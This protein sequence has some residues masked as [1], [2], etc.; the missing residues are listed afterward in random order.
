MMKF[1]VTLRSMMNCIKKVKP[2]DY[3]SEKELS[4]LL[5]ENP[6]KDLKLEL[7]CQDGKHYYVNLQID[8]NLGTVKIQFPYWSMPRTERNIAFLY[9]LFLAPR[10]K[11]STVDGIT[12][13]NNYRTERS[14]TKTKKKEIFDNENENNKTN[15]RK[16]RLEYQVY[17]E[18]DISKPYLKRRKKTTNLFSA[19]EYNPE[20]AISINEKNNDKSFD[21]NEDDSS[22]DTLNDMN[23]DFYQNSLLI[24]GESKKNKK[25]KNESSKAT[26]NNQK[27]FE[28]GKNYENI[29]STKEIHTNG[30]NHLITE[31]N[32]SIGSS[33]NG[34][35]NNYPQDSH[36]KDVK[37]P[38]ETAQDGLIS[39]A[40]EI[41]AAS[42][43]TGVAKSKTKLG[44][45]L[46]PLDPSVSNDKNPS[47]QDE[48]E[49]ID[50]VDFD[51][52][53]SSDLSKENSKNLEKTD[54]DIE[55]AGSKLENPIDLPVKDHL[56][57]ENSKKLDLQ[58]PVKIRGNPLFSA[59]SGELNPEV[60]KSEKL[61]L[62][63]PMVEQEIP[64]ILPYNKELNPEEE[65]S[66][67]SLQSQYADVFSEC[68]DL[69]LTHDRKKEIL[70]LDKQLMK[71]RKDY[72]NL[73][74]GLMN[75]SAN[76]ERMKEK[77][78][79]NY[80]SFID[81][82][83]LEK[84]YSED[85]KTLN[86]TLDNMKKLSAGRLKKTSVVDLEKDLSDAQKD[87]DVIIQEIK[88]IDKLLSQEKV[89]L[90]EAIRSFED[91]KQKIT[92]IKARLLADDKEIIR[93]K[94][95]LIELIVNDAVVK[96]LKPKMFDFVNEKL[97]P[98]PL[99]EL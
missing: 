73:K 31:D 46:K 6:S 98:D 50:D 35:K 3:L 17:K 72:N 40:S 85:L 57:P 18:E 12:K 39:T 83:N 56:N 44:K 24:V 4:K 77:Y 67:K 80:Q 30:E 36:I 15:K 2:A 34:Q 84:K 20:N 89:V 55:N 64:S 95:K 16:S 81:K 45:E 9:D 38:S 82:T 91:K 53:S 76:L 14:Q 61:D 49:S 65:E 5:D 66:E 69:V 62:H 21:K 10:G 54:E 48:L 7:L 70:T 86:D 87:H 23:N 11:F 29:T 93:V 22:T 33:S 51:E 68:F 59:V 60:E 88:E 28:S 13:K 74:I 97:K 37:N 71:V 99:D 52:G 8:K 43:K 41:S 58:K 78:N 47:D 26:E 27:I 96:Y 79:E 25:R 19:H 32:K 1:D 94:E 63:K 75:S 92:G 42:E 90:D